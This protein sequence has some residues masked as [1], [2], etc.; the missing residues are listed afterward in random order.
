MD[1]EG[2]CLGSTSPAD[3]FVPPCDGPI[4]AWV[5]V[6]SFVIC[7]RL[8]LLVNT[9]RYWLARRARQL[10]FD[11]HGGNAAK[12]DRA[13]RRMPVLV[14]VL[15]METATYVAALGV[16]FWVADP[17]S[18]DSVVLALMGVITVLF[19]FVGTVSLNHFI[20]AFAS[21]AQRH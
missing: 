9:L 10:H 18:R 16:P 7:I 15:V 17:A 5:A 3:F 8:G 21:S 2:F 6:M 1:G 12:L 20:R 11:F 14:V 13:R 19:F 4:D